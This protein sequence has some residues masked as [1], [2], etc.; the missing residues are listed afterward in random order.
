M[1]H[2]R[3]NNGRYIELFNELPD[4]VCVEL[5]VIIDAE[6]RHVLYVLNKITGK[7]GSLVRDDT[8]VRWGMIYEEMGGKFDI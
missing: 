7:S 4:V 3:W 5:T 8:V 2:A 1:G 6:P